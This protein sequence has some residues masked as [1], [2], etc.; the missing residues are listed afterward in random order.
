MIKL[1][2]LD[3]RARIRT[4]KYISL[5][6]VIMLLV[7]GIVI[8][9]LSIWMEVWNIGTC[10]FLREYYIPVHVHLTAGVLTLFVIMI[11]F[12]CTCRFRSSW[13]I[14]AF[15]CILAIIVFFRIDG[16]HDGGHI[17]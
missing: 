17:G 2:H 9:V 14:R 10:K 7:H 12:I 4:I 1:P 15:A 3:G 13:Y 16:R 5:V 11:S 6:F 8:T